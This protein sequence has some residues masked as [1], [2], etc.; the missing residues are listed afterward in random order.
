MG[1]RCREF[2]TFR[3]DCGALRLDGRQALRQDVD[4]RRKGSQLVSARHR[5]VFGVVAG[6][7]AAHRQGDPLRASGGIRCHP[8]AEE[9][10]HDRAEHDEREQQAQIVRRRD[11]HQ[12]RDDQH[13]EERD[14]CAGEGCERRLRSNA[15]IGR[16]IDSAHR[17]RTRD[18]SRRT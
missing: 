15:D 6:C 12:L 3:I 18:D 2:A 16:A 5:D 17:Q 7:Q 11:E 4:V 8:D 9:H 14:C 13:V 10:R 1:D